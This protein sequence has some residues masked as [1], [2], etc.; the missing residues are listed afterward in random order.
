MSSSVRRNARLR[1]EYI[2]R[3]SLKGA[4]LAEYE[5]KQRVKEALRD[6]KPIPTELAG[7]AHSLEAATEWDDGA[8]RP[9]RLIDDEYAQADSEPKIMITSSRRP[10]P[11]LTQFVKELKLLF[12][13]SQRMNRGNHILAELA[14]ASRRHGVTDLIVAHETRGLPDGLIISHLPHGPTAYFT[15]SNVVMR[16]DIR[17][18]IDAMSLQNPHLIFDKF[19]TPLGKRVMTI[20]QHLFPPPKSESTRIVTFANEDDF[21]FFRHHT[22][23]PKGP[24]VELQEVGP[25]FEMKLY[26]IRLG[27][28][29]QAEA[30]NEWVLRPFMN[31]ARKRT[32]L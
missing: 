20:L 16:H 30:D 29:E 27:T 17:E 25:R 3:R 13:G 21:I 24:Q 14:A 23:E 4:E 2:Y 5:K 10:S 6:G 15:L 1:K 26:K 31:T 12:P 8:V 18:G 9:P 11:K 19:S 32:L 22:F 7:F 28:L